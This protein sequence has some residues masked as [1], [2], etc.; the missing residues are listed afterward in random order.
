[1]KKITDE[2]NF[3]ALIHSDFM[4]KMRTLLDTRQYVLDTES[5]KIRPRHPHLSDWDGPW[6][7]VRHHPEA[8]CNLWH[9]VIFNNFKFIPEGCLSCWKVVVRPQ[10]LEDL[11]KLLEFQLELDRPSKC[12]TELRP[13]VYGAYGGY[14]YNRSKEEGLECYKTV[15]EG[16]KKY[17]INFL[18]G[19]DGPIKPLL[20]R[21][22]TEFEMEKGA[23]DKWDITPQDKELE[24]IVTMHVDANK[25]PQPK[26]NRVHIVR[27]WIDQAYS[28]GDPTVWKFNDN[29]PFYPSYVTYHKEAEDAKV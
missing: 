10:W 13:N 28:I 16:C 27:Q 7:H 17:K 26:I 9:K 29:Q 12:G 18:I 5:G 19:K 1:M 25:Y 11:F 21:G 23:S 2:Y 6:F 20:K 14:F 3:G 8:D 15:I 22:C 4:E 24:K